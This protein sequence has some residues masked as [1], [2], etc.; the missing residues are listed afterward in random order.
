MVR[1]S[2]GAS[3]PR[4]FASD[5]PRRGR[6]GKK[7]KKHIPLKAIHYA[8]LITPGPQIDFDQEWT[9]APA[10]LVKDQPV[11][12]ASAD[13]LI[14]MKSSERPKDLED[15]ALLKRAC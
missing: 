6:H 3:A 2:P 10:A 9:R 12:I 7:P 1:F 13:L 11:R 15:I 4:V 5:Q 8:D 14:R